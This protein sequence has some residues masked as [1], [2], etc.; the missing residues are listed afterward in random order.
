MSHD[1]DERKDII[2]LEVG[3]DIYFF[4]EYLCKDQSKS[5]RA[6]GTHL[7]GFLIPYKTRSL[8]SHLFPRPIRYTENL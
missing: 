1:P 3:P 6:N 5:K 7:D 2:M 4:Q 8:Y